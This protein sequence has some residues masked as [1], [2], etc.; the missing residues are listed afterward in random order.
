MQ[1]M[2]VPPTEGD[3]AK[4]ITLTKTRPPKKHRADQQQFARHRMPDLQ[5]LSMRQAVAQLEGEKVRITLAG[6]GILVNQRPEPGTAL[7]EGCEVFLEFAPP[8]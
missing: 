2:G 6:S 8:L 7:T 1:Y 3:F 4:N 5:G